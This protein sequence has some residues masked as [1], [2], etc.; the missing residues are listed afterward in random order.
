MAR[1]QKNEME[2]RYN[3]NLKEVETAKK[4]CVEVKKLCEVECNSLCL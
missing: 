1:E 2:E 3:D 4:G